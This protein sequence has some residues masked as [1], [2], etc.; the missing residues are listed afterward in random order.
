MVYTRNDAVCAGCHED[1]AKSYAR[2]PMG[3]SLVP[4]A[5]LLPGLGAAVDH[6][7]GE[8]RA[9]RLPVPGLGRGPVGC[10]HLMRVGDAR[11]ATGTFVRVP[12]QFA[13]AE[14]ERGVADADD[15]LFRQ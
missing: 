10:D 14:P 6:V 1:I 2:H 13:A 15:V 11:Q 3:R 5:D 4:A 12:A 8:Q 7:V 9:E